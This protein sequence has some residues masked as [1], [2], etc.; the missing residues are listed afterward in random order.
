MVQQFHFNAGKHPFVSKAPC[1]AIPLITGKHSHSPGP[2]HYWLQ[3]LSKY[4]HRLL[5][6]QSDS[7]IV[8]FFDFFG[9]FS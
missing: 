2:F 1:K 7:F 3:Q 5:Q 6:W 8:N 4:F 9:I